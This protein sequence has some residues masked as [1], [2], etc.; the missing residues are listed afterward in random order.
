[1]NEKIKDAKVDVACFGM[2]TPAHVMIVDEIPAHNTGI[3]W[4]QMQE[5]ISDDAAIVAILLKQWGVQTGLIA[6]ALGDDP[7]GHQTVQRLREI[8][9]SGDFRISKE[10]TTPYELN[11]S[12]KTGART[13]FWKRDPKVLATL[14]TADLSLISDAKALY[15]DW[16][17]QEHILRA[18][19]KAHREGV[20]VFLNFEHGHEDVDLLER[21]APLVSICQATTDAA[22]LMENAQDVALKLLNSG[23]STVLVTMARQGCLGATKDEMVRVQAP[24]VEVVDGCAA[25]ATFSAGYIYGVLMGWDMEESL[26]FAISAASLQCTAVGPTA[27]PLESIYELAVTLDVTVTK[28]L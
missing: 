5:F 28:T 7:L 13:Y 18:M 20:P 25:G 9:I 22:Q 19:N 4:K 15:A 26:R 10:I 6:T 2:V 8:G 1:M 12:D 3:Q 17:D 23:I 21:Y 27:F 14:D 16:Y 24:E 11:V